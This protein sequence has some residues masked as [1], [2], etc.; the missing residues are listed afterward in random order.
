MTILTVVLE[1][2]LVVAFLAA[3]CA[4]IF[5]WTPLGRRVVNAVVA[6]QFLLGVVLAA[7]MGSAHEPLPPQLWG[8]LI[9]AVLVMACYG[10]AMRAG[11]QAGGARRALVL[12]IAGLALVIIN[13]LLGVHMTL[14]AAQ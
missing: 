5:S 1:I 9:V 6:L 4:L 3:L 7:L 14:G 12:S 13:I 2:H 10:F 8:H 11:K